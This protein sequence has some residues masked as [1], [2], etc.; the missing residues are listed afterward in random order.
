MLF[1][2]AL[3][4]GGK[5]WSEHEILESILAIARDEPCP[6]TYDMEKNGRDVSGD[7]RKTR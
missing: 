3:F 7:G 4:Q 6:D 5:K 1:P 2:K